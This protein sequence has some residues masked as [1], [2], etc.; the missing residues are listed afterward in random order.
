MMHSFIAIFEY[1]Q[2]FSIELPRSI[3]MAVAIIIAPR[4]SMRTA[5]QDH[6]GCAA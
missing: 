2:I 1:L 4:F 3:H 6:G 5:A